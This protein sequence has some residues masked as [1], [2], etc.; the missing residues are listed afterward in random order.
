MLVSFRVKCADTRLGFH[1][2]AVGSTPALG[3]WDPRKGIALTTSPDD[4]PVWKS[5][6][7]LTVDKGSICEYK[8]IICDDTG[9]TVQWEDGA[10]RTLCVVE[11]LA[12]PSVLSISESWMTYDPDHVRF[13][14]AQ[15]SAPGKASASVAGGAGVELILKC[16]ETRVGWH[17]RVVGSPPALGGWDPHKGIALCTSAS[18]FPVWRSQPIPLEG[19]AEYKFVICDDT[20][21]AVVWEERANRTMRDLTSG[22]LAPLSS[23]IAVYAVWGAQADDQCD[24]RSC[25]ANRTL[26]APRAS[27][28]LERKASKSDL[29]GMTSERQQARIELEKAPC[30]DLLN[31][32]FATKV[33]GHI[34]GLIQKGESHRDDR[35]RVSFGSI[36]SALPAFVACQKG[37]KAFMQSCNQ[38]NFSVTHFNS[39]HTLVCAFDGHGPYGHLVAT[40]AVQTVP[41]FMVNES[42]FSGA[43]DEEAVEEALTSAFEKA[44]RDLVIHSLENYWDVEC[45]GC[46]A[47]AV[48][49]KKHKVWT[50]NAGDC[51][52]VLGSEVDGKVIFATEDHKA[53]IQRERD[54]IEAMGGEVLVQTGGGVTT[55][56]VLAA[57]GKVGL[58]AARALGDQSLK[59]YGVCATPEVVLTTVDLSKKVF[60]IVASDGMWQFLSSECVVEAVA[61]KV[62]KVGP[63]KTL[64]L[65]QQKAFREWSDHD[66][67]YCD[68]ITAVL[69]QLW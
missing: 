55:S 43:V 33:R 20:G 6:A 18:D 16:A 4:F 22:G 58:S 11:G 68:D 49:F 64:E 19:E 7:P 26:C 65:L 51:R 50:C 57:G 9:A 27:T 47:V 45:S 5:A 10:N 56:R 2:R 54:R 15:P 8:Y 67:N 53:H 42:G 61:A 35:E 38:D 28:L 12:P 40:R 37:H 46:T 14:H 60:V 44:Q 13:G 25:D 66:G 3:A 63:A 69:V 34:H 36:P 29:D 23:V 21:H 32:T 31:K 1:V 52:A 17:V 39:G 41:W 48:L 59:K 24:L 30:Q 62:P